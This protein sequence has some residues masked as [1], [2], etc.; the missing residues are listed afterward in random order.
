MVTRLAV[1]EVPLWQPVVGL[2]L[3]AAS[4]YVVVLLTGRLFRADTLLSSS[5]LNWAR[6]TRE[7]RK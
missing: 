1:G 6:V 2:V 4:V 7:L 5:A 3:L